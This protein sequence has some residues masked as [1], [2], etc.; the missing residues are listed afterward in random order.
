MNAILSLT[1]I[2]ITYAIGDIISVKTKSIVSTM[3]TC[4]VIFIVGFWLGIPQTLFTDSQLAGIG[5]LLITL[6]L[7]HMGTLMSLKQ[8]KEQWKVV[9]VACVAVLGITLVLL[10]VGP[11]LIG[12][13]ESLVA[14]PVISGGLIA[15]LMMQDAVV[16]AGL[17]NAD[18]LVVFATVLMVME[19]CCTWSCSSSWNQFCYSYSWTNAY[20]SW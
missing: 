3:F 9:L 11:I 10:T 18:A 20:R 12:R 1:F 19:G 15:A 7:V 16:K 17:G 13:A 5:S 2:F 14:A 8:L 4:S 6:L